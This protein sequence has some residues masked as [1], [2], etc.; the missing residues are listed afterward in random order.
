M[1]T[2]HFGFV[3]RAGKYACFL[4]PV[5]NVSNIGENVHP[6]SQIVVPRT[7]F[8]SYRN[9]METILCD[10]SAFEFLR[11]PPCV[12]RLSLDTPDLSTSRDRQ[13][14]HRHDRFLGY[15]RVPLHIL[16]CNRAHMHQSTAFIR[17]LWT[18]DLPS[19]SLV[20]ID[21]YHSVTSPELTLL[22]LARHLPLPQLALAMYELT[23]T[24]SE[25]HLT[26]EHRNELK[27]RMSQA[28]WRG[29]D[30]WRPVIDVRGNITDQWYR[31]PLTTK[32][33]LERF[34]RAVGNVRGI[35]RFR[36]AIDL[37]CGVA[38][39]SFEA[40]SAITIGWERYLG[41]W[42]LG[43]MLLNY[44]VPFDAGARTI[45][46]QSY[47]RVDLFLEATD[48]LPALGIECQGRSVH[49]A[50]G[51]TEHDADRLLAL[52]STGLPVILVTYQQIENQKRFQ[53]LIQLI[54]KKRG[55][56]LRPK[57]PRQA[58]KERELRYQVLHAWNQLWHQP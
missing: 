54:A 10:I 37:L 36:Q 26:A 14:L 3:K 5:R 58:A 53:E 23:G 29:E 46:G 42:G 1:L 55:A 52:E 57:T 16:E 51:I 22:L 35:R 28:G 30:G 19:G 48:S 24:Y 56:K 49:G 17:H 50:S 39:S 18:G 34:A 20:E 43:Q 27:R 21:A 8:L 44:N 32:E 13:S 9:A 45:A 7:T 40:K 11:I 12:L 25:I 31:E 15:V 47:A 41:G 2:S 38:G 4:L 6:K 33:N